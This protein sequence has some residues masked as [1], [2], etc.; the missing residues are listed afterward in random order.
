[1]I[2]SQW[3][4]SK[5]AR[6]SKINSPSMARRVDEDTKDSKVDKADWICYPLAAESSRRTASS[7]SK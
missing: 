5:P 7:T 2:L 6:N 3:Q 4:H 1:M